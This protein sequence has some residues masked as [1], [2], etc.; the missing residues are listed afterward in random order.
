MKHIFRKI[1]LREIRTNKGRFLALLAI[2]ALGVG[3]LSGLLSA[4]PMM[5][6]S[7]DDYYDSMNFHDLSV[8][9]TL[10]LDSDDIAALSAVSGVKSVMPFYQKDVTATV[11][12][13]DTRT[14]RIVSRDF[15]QIANKSENALDRPELIAGRFP[16]NADECVVMSKGKLGESTEIG[17]VFTVREENEDWEDALSRNRF[18]VV[19]LVKD[20]GYFSIERELTNIGSGTLQ[21]ILYTTEGAFSYEV[22][23]TAYLTLDEAKKQDTY[24]EEYERIRDSLSDQIRAT[25]DLRC[26]AR[27]D[28]IVS[29]AQKEIEKGQAEYDTQKQLAQAELDAAKQQLDDAQEQYDDGLKAWQ[30][31]EDEYESG[32]AEYQSG[33]AQLNEQRDTVNAKLQSAQ[34]EIAA[35]RK[36][37]EESRAQLDAAAPQVQLLKQ[38]ID[39]LSSD[40]PDAFEHLF[41]PDGQTIPENLQQLIQLAQTVMHS[42][43]PE[44]IAALVQSLHETYDD[45]IE[46]YEA[47]L[48][49]LR[50]GEQQLQTASDQLTQ[51]QIAWA[52]GEAKAQEKLDAAK[53]QLDAAKAE[54]DTSRAELNAAQSELEKGRE[55]YE[56]AKAEADRKLADAEK[57]LDDARA[58][59]EA[60]DSPSWTV[61]D[62]SDN[63]SFQSF[64][65]N[66]EKL[67]AIARVFPIFFFLVAA[68]VALTT[69]TRMIEEQRVLIGTLKALGY[70][71]G[72]IMAKFLLYAASATAM[73]C[74]VG[75]ALGLTAL[76]AVIWNAYG[77]MYQFPALHLRFYPVICLTASLVAIISVQVATYAAC[78]GTL[79]ESPAA[80]M[81]PKAPRAGKRIWLEHIRFVWKHMNFSMKVTA[82]NLFRYKKRLFMTIFGVAGCTALLLT[83]FG[84]RD[85]IGGICDTQF[86]ELQSY[87]LTVYCDEVTGELTEHLDKR[88]DVRDYLPVLQRQVTADNPEQSD[89]TLTAYTVIPK[90]GERLT[91]FV[92]MRTRKTHEPVAFD[93]QAVITE[94]LANTLNIGIGDSIR[95]TDTDN[96]SFTVPVGGI[97]ENYISSYVYIPPELYESASGESFEE[98]AVFVG[99]TGINDSEARENMAA[100]L[101]NTDGVLSAQFTATVQESFNNIIHG[102]DAVIV[103]IIVCAAALAFVVLY[104]LTNINITERQRELATLKVLG[105]FRGETA[106]YIFRE[107][108]LLTLLGA[109]AGLGLGVLLHAY[110]IRTVEVDMVMFGRIIAPSSFVFA[111]VLTVLFSLLVDLSMLPKLNRINMVESLKSV[112]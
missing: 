110:V 41:A 57:Q 108:L 1:G 36:S 104:N 94:K 62:R 21:D 83:G 2:S 56:Q 90:Q 25:G 63:L 11:K 73:G 70:K 61:S 48:A 89:K 54:L 69:M 30:E 39:V 85:S 80:L 14:V 87:D 102:I 16:Q 98:N 91:D 109:A 67:E 17:E 8:I 65:D 103:L 50:Q 27:Y 6:G 10:G 9:S 95:L 101:L 76:P 31:G 7:M 18:T 19:G 68:L 71:N 26:R 92:T 28:G 86:G 78:R 37:L 72:A 40:D 100:Q 77:I 106:M 81:L 107:I 111:A 88:T 93:R 20:S 97:I 12:S 44:Q 38:L 23:T 112:D 96:K 64:A 13:G 47:G 5:R 58:E 4:G 24:S 3:F 75:L 99:T 51:E 34:E 42:G 46:Q 49:A 33:V 105:F 32:L 84:L 43:N 29:E 53:E 66:M 15:E 52:A 79:R 55:E 45:D 74:L 82:R 59:L 22:Y 35:G 60:F